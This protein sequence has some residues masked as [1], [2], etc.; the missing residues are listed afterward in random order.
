MRRVGYM[1]TVGSVDANV[2]LIGIVVMIFDMD[3]PSCIAAIYLDD[4]DM[5]MK[6]CSSTTFVLWRGFS[7]IGS[8]GPKMEL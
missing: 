1:Q 5:V 7:N 6:L 2:N 8:Q 4:T 3:G